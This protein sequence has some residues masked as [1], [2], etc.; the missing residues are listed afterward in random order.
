MI[1]WGNLKLNRG[2]LNHGETVQQGT[3][4]FKWQLK[5]RTYN[6]SSIFTFLFKY[7]NLTAL[8]DFR[9]KY[10]PIKV[11]KWPTISFS[12]EKFNST[13]FRAILISFISELDFNHLFVVF[14][15]TF[16]NKFDLIDKIIYCLF[17]FLLLCIQY[18]VTL[19]S[20]NNIFI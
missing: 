2:K 10:L 19:K 14:S 8:K 4:I 6:H 17:L 13:Y 18:N 16:C 12:L 1:I 9:H 5:S 15:N 20:F 3:K 7:S 11:I